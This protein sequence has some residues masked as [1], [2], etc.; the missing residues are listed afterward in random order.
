MAIEFVQVYSAF[1]RL[2]GETVRLFLEAKGLHPILSQESVGSVYGL[3]FGPLGEVRI[4]VPLEEEEQA[5]SLLA[6]MDDGSFEN[7]ESDQLT[8]E[9]EK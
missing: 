2:Q 3:T 1:G 4:L 8:D 5:L 6:Q 9:P 7:P